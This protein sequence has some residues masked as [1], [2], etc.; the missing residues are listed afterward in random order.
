M[1]LHTKKK[2]SFK[3]NLLIGAIS[4]L[5]AGETW[6]DG[7]IRGQ[8]TAQL[9]GLPLQGSRVK[10]EELNVSAVTARD[11]RFVLSGIA[12][13]DY[14]LSVSYLGV[15]TL[16]RQ[17]SV[18][19]N[20][21]LISNFQIA[22]TTPNTEYLIVLGQAGSL[23][24]ALNRQRSAD[25]VVS[26]VAADAIGQLPDTNVS[27]ALQRLPGLS[28]ER[29][30]GEG[31]YVRV[32]GLGPDYNAVTINGVS[33]PSPDSGRRAVALDVIPSD[34][35]EGLVV[36][37]TLTPDMDANALGG[38]IDIQSLS[39]F[40]RDDMFYSFTAEGSYNDLTEESSPK[41]AL[42][43][44]DKFSIGS[45]EDN[46]GIAGGISWYDRSFGSDNIETGGGWDF[47]DDGALLEEVE[48][49]DYTIS[50]ERSGLTLNL[51]YKPSENTDLYWRNLFSKYTDA[52]VR[53]A[54]IF[55]YEDGVMA[56]EEGVA[57]IER[58]LKDRTE[59]QEIFSTSLGGTTRAGNWTLDYRAAL[60]ESGED[61]PEHVSGAV[62][63]GS[64]AFAGVSFTDT[65]QPW[66]YTPANFVDPAAYELDE[67]EWASSQTND[68]ERS[69]QFDITRDMFVG[70]N[71]V[72]L[73][74]GGKYRQREKDNDVSVWVFGDFDEHG[75]SDEQRSFSAYSANGPDYTL[76]TFG[77]GI[78]ANAV[79]GAI[80]PLD[81]NEFYEE[82]DS[83]IED[84]TVQEDVAAAYAMGR[85]DIGN[86]RVLGGVR[87][88]DTDFNAAGTKYDGDEFSDTS[89]SKQY[90]HILPSLHA[91][92]S[93]GE[94]TQMRASWSNALVRPNFEQVAPFFVIDDE[95]AEFGNP[96]LEA[97]ESS[98]LDVGFE[99]YMGIAGVF[100]AFAY[101]KEIDNFIYQ[102][103]L[104]G[105]PGFT[106]YDEAVTFANGDEAEILG[107][108]LALSKQLDFLPAPFN[109]L[110]IS[111]NATFSDSEA[112]L[113][114]YDEDDGAMSRTIVMPSQ[115][116]TTGNLSVGY[117][118]S[119]F[120]VRLAA[121]YKS[122]YLLE[123]GDVS[124]SEE[125]VYV[126]AQTQL[127]LSARYY[128]TDGVQVYLEAMNLTDEPYYAYLN[129][130][131]Y[132]AQYESYGM[133]FKMGVTVTN[134]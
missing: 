24:K 5:A 49:R 44:S 19:D 71:A 124:D 47:D 29:D 121:N 38:S 81:K 96:D 102:T 108:E 129:D 126:D 123:V 122:E 8:L 31:R 3:R 133:T 7:Q 106:E 60:S 14:T 85:I 36:S 63:A 33:L 83:R 103:D 91:R 30:Q 17:V 101:Y 89:A 1:T 82:E 26:A 50:R 119:S 41:L 45:G 114:Y 18:R 2:P 69:F 76:G 57:E 75:F 113:D 56:G 107:A 46:F 111:A 115:S 77:P 117:E 58:E 16:N 112:T 34:L 72:Q 64:D 15:E 86:L 130:R 134:F 42:T 70:N 128:I 27:E 87:Y 68:E 100:S 110:L 55:E 35:L 13:G 105:T 52:E 9:S 132:N 127:D 32:R 94:N 53:L 28:I 99:H 21:T 66:M 118:S 131:S 40:D 11:G 4:A 37:K 10:I 125:D 51:D 48:Q 97:M 74:V 116:D 23:N 98:N 43:A 95:E 67:V 109:G 65:V 120:S 6:A 104:A 39:A 84:F 62:F 54:N 73:K 20:E 59:T 12:A 92:Y 79:A 25:N 61:E 93:L 90:D 78:N 80:A 88:E 22:P